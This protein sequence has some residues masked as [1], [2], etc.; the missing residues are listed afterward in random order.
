MTFIFYNK[1]EIFYGGVSVANQTHLADLLGL[2]I[3]KLRVRYLGV[4]L[5]AGKLKFE[6]N[7]P[8]IDQMSSRITS[9]TSRLSYF[10]SRLQLT[11]SVLYSVAN[12]WCSMFILPTKVIKKVE[13]ICN[14]FLWKG[15][16]GSTPGAKVSWDGVCKT[17]E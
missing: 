8:L 4:P 12:F 10:A 6:D 16:V 3:G 15:V 1:S 9:W 7:K 11:E 5:I 13:K 2:K 14:A 17:K